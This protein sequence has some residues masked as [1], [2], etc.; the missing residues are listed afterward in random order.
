[1]QVNG[2]G[3]KTTTRLLGDALLP[4]LPLEIVPLYFELDGSFPNHPA[5]PLEPATLLI[6]RKRLLSTAQTSALP[7]TAMP[8]VAS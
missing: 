3:G 7:L 4:A 5:N 2:M 6:C 8:T 1:M